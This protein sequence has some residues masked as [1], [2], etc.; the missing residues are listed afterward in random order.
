MTPS[1]I[2]FVKYRNFWKSLARSREFCLYNQDPEPR[3][4]M[5]ERSSVDGKIKSFRRI[6]FDDLAIVL[7]PCGTRSAW[8]TLTKCPAFP[9]K[10]SQ[11]EKAKKLLAQIALDRVLDCFPEMGRESVEF[12]EFLFDYFYVIEMDL[13]DEEAW[14]LLKELEIWSTRWEVFYEAESVLYAGYRGSRFGSVV[15]SVDAE[16]E[17][18]SLD[19]NV[20]DSIDWLSRIA[21]DGYFV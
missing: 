11:D 10:W 19:V 4:I 16:K 14:Y 17:D 15:T 21:I 2:C 20:D 6:D 5:I 9:S 13:R 8:L 12:N 7:S 3:N 1:S 18:Y